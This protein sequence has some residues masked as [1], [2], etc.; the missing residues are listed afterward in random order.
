MSDDFR[1]TKRGELSLK[2]VID[3]ARRNNHQHVYMEVL[4]DALELLGW[5][6]ELGFRVVQNVTTTRNELVLVK[7]L[8]HPQGPLHLNHLNIILPTDRSLLVTEAYIVPIKDSFHLSAILCDFDKNLFPASDAC[9]N[10]IR[11]AYLCHAIPHECDLVM[12][13]IPPN[14][15]RNSKIT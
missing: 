13:V 1:G 2:A 8:F 11:K 15:N 14:Q 12:L 5:L 9:G 3:Y 7:D 10:A 6:E 4:P